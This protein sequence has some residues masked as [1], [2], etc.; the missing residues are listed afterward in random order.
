MAARQSNAWSNRDKPPQ[1]LAKAMGAGLLFALAACA[2]RFALGYPL[3]HN[4]EGSWLVIARELDQGVAWPVSG[5]AFIATLREASRQFDTSHAS[6]MPWLGVAGVFVV[7]S[8]LC[9]GYRTLG[10]VRPSTVFA[11]LMLSSYFWA[12]LL[13]ARPQQWGQ[14]LVFL[15]TISAWLWLCQRGGWAV[16][17]FLAA[18][19]FTHIL[20]HA[21]LAFLCTALVAADFMEKRPMTRRH[22]TL[23]LGIAASAGIYAWPGGPYSAML[24]DLRQ[25]HL[26]A[27]TLDHSGWLLVACACAL[28]LWFIRH[29]WQRH[30]HAAHAVADA[31]E[32]HKKAFACGLFSALLLA[33]AVQAHLLPPQ[34]LQLYQGSWL[35]FLVFQSGNLLFAGLFMVGAHI[36]IQGLR[37]HRYDPVMGRFLVWILAAVAGLCLLSVAASWWL[38]DTNW[39]LRVLNYGIFFAALPAAIGLQRLARTR[40]G[41]TGL[42][43]LA[44]GMA[45]SLLSVLRHPLL[46]AC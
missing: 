11:T 36:L 15:G 30:S 7:A 14:L 8:G 23:V 43:V 31:L 12:P 9:W 38:L 2:L 33:L 40:L 1:A 22:L 32:R 21:I 26:K 44:A 34:A 35:R 25:A 20:S 37:H 24:V 18:A 6:L 29:R 4:D 3:C 39:F 19:A 46:L 41:G 17:P 13:E 16:F 45:A 28:A 27:W 5:P 42:L 10:M